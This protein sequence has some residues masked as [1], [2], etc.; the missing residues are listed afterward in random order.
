[1]TKCLKSTGKTVIPFITVE[2]IEEWETVFASALNHD[3]G[4]GTF[5]ELNKVHDEKFEE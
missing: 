3:D 5:C 4:G 2:T 1:L